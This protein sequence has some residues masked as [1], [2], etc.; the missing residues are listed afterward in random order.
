MLCAITRERRCRPARREHG[1][2]TPGR[3]Y[4]PPPDA[5]A[6]VVALCLH[7]PGRVI[8][9][10]FALYYLAQRM[11]TPYHEREPHTVVRV[12]RRLRARFVRRYG[13]YGEGEDAALAVAAGV[14]A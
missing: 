4:A 3:R 2:R 8:L 13:A 9:V 5:R 1:T 14:A 7:Y 12:G 10:L 11:R 6:H